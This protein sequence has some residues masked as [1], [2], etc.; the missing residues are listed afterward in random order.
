MI[1]SANGINLIKE[2]ERYFPEAYR[3]PKGVWTIGWG[4]TRYSDGSPVR[5][6]DKI[7]TDHAER[8]LHEHLF[9]LESEVSSV[10]KVPVS[11]CQFDALVS[12]A[13]NCGMGALKG[14]TL[15]K[16]INSEGEVDISMFVRWSKIKTNEGTKTLKGLVKRRIS[17]F[18]LFTTGELEFNFD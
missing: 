6:G 7:T 9:L 1:I 18:H 16:T 4:S 14:S 17:E 11:Q 8:L 13:Y 12:F 2:Y 10:L 15:L 5:Q 3:C